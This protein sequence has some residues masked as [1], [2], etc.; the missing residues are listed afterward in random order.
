MTDKERFEKA[1]EDGI[2]NYYSDDSIWLQNSVVQWNEKMKEGRAVREKIRNI[3]TIFLGINLFFMVAVPI[4]ITVFSIL[5]I[6]IDSIFCMVIA[7]TIYSLVVIYCIG[8]EKKR[9]EL[10]T[11]CGLILLIV[12][13]YAF[14]ILFL[15]NI[16]FCIVYHNKLIVYEAMPGYPKFTN[17]TIKHVRRGKDDLPEEYK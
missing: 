12:N 16:I 2:I 6:T 17:I 15:I 13:W 7:Y 1:K 9:F 14:L 4:L 11:L 5:S 10:C 8:A 3:P